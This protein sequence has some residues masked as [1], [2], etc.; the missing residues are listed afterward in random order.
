M[1][2]LVWYAVSLQGQAGG[3]CPPCATLQIAH[4]GADFQ[5]I[6][7]G[8]IPA[9]TVR[10]L[11]AAT[12]PEQRHQ[13]LIVAAGLGGIVERLIVANPEGDVPGLP[14]CPSVES[15]A[16]GLVC[17]DVISLQGHGLV[18]LQAVTVHPLSH[19]ALTVHQQ[20]QHV[21]AAATMGGHATRVP[22]YDGA[23]G[24]GGQDDTL[25]GSA[26]ALDVNEHGQVVESEVDHGSG[27]LVDV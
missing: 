15:V 7:G 19:A 24:Q 8:V 14:V 27:R 1:G 2:R 6:D 20:A 9:A 18:V 25:T 22:L 17:V 21:T 26:G 3:L 4:H 10:R 11:L 12:I 16:H 5:S 13:L 23:T